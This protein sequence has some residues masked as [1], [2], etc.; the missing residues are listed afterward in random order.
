MW[1]MRVWTPFDLIVW[2]HHGHTCGPW[3]GCMCTV[4]LKIHSTLGGLLAVSLCLKSG[5]RSWASSDGNLDGCSSPSSAYSFSKF[6]RYGV[7]P[8][9]FIMLKPSIV[10]RSPSKSCPA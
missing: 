2:P 10:W 9:S 4:L 3:N 8:A 7:K 5:F 6:W 1:S